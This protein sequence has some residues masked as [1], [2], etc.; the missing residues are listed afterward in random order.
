MR[1]PPQQQQPHPTVTV[2][3]QPSTQP[4]DIADV[5]L[6]DMYAE[7]R[8]LAAEHALMRNF[9]YREAA[10]AFQTGQRAAA[11]D[12]AARGHWHNAEMHKAHARGGEQI[13][14]QRNALVGANAIDLHGLHVKEAMTMLTQRI[15]ALQRQGIRSLFVITGAGKH[16]VTGTARIKQAVLKFCHER[17]LRYKEP[18][19]GGIVVYF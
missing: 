5:P 9:Y 17:R 12:L 8:R 3:T 6:A 15:D 1:K 16:S 7:A 2:M 19:S 10:R 13:F 11:K 14:S 18:Q 4:T